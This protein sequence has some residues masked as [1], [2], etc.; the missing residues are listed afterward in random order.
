MPPSIDLN[1]Q[2]FGSLAVIARAG[3]RADGRTAMYDRTGQM[4]PWEFELPI[5]ELEPANA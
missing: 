2:R 1:G 3:S 4:E 5:E